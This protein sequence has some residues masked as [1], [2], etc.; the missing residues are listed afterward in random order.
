MATIELVRAC[1]P[2]GR[3]EIAREIR[4]QSVNGTAENCHELADVAIKRGLDA[5][6]LEV[7]DGMEDAYVMRRG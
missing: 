4:Y 2:V 6:W 3:K 5:G 1:G 7:Y